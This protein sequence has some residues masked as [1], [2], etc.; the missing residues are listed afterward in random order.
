MRDNA[1]VIVSL[2]YFMVS[3]G[4]KPIGAE[5]LMASAPDSFPGEPFGA[6]FVPKILSPASPRPGTM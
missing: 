4:V 6:Y 2:S 1:P 5:D 3:W